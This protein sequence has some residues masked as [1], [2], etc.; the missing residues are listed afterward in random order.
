[1]MAW[2]VLKGRSLAAK[3]TITLTGTKL[4]RGLITKTFLFKAK[5][6]ARYSRSPAEPRPRSGPGAVD[7]YA[8]SKPWASTPRSSRAPRSRAHRRLDRELTRTGRHGGCSNTA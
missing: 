4:H 3:Q 5:G 8:C 2:E 6:S 1:V 7:T